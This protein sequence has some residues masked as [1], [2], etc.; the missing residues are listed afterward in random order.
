M[1]LLYMD[2]FDVQDS[3]LRWVQNGPPGD[4]TYAAATRFGTGK[5]LTINAITSNTSN[6]SILKSFTPSASVYMGAALQVG[7]EVDTNNSNH[8]GNLFGIYTDNATTGHIYLRRLNTNAIVAY[9]GDPNLG[10]LGSP[11]GTQI[12]ASA[13]GVLDGSWRYIEVYAVIN[14]TTGRLTVKVD[15]NTVIDFTGDT[16]N[17]GTST[18]IDAI[19]FRTGKYISNNNSV[20]TID[21]LYVCDA[22]GTTNNT[23]LGDVRVQTMLPNAAGSSTQLAPTGSVNNWANAAEVPFNNST[24]NASA[25]VG[26]LDLYGLS[27]L[28]GSTMT[29]RGVQTVAHMQKSDSGTAN[30]KIA[31]KS[32]AS[33]YYD[34]T[35]SLGTSPGAYTQ[36]REIDPATSA[37]WTVEGANS[38]EAGM[39]VA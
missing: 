26:Q 17:A 27:D 35:R 39:E 5:A 9:R 28:V 12:A 38:L 4:Y 32:G 29:V 31:L 7:L 30:A 25:T 37:A 1:A 23:F 16:R 8:T 6:V 11:N 21:D 10:T 24:Y 19:R 36:V 34:A 33:V 20:I 18:N 13:S 15:G 22:T 14:D 3:S 2:G